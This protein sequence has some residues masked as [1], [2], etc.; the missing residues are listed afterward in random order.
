[1]LGCSQLIHL[2]LRELH[3]ELT[4]KSTSLRLLTNIEGGLTTIL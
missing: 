3:Q 1:V 2:S 4:E